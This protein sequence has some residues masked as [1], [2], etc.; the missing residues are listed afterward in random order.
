MNSKMDSSDSN[1]PGFPGPGTS[2]AT[3]SPPELNTAGTEL[4]LEAKS[5]KNAAQAMD[6]CRGLEANNKQRALRSADIQQLHD[7]KPPHGS[8][9]QLASAKSWQANASTL[10]LAGIVGRVSQRFVNA[11]ISQTYVTASAL[12]PIYKDWKTKSD[13]LRG[14]FTSLV[15]GW[16]GN[17]GLI[18]AI[19][20]E[21]VLQGYAY[22][23]FLDPKTWL[24]TFFKQE[25]CLVPEKSGQHARDLQ[26]FCARRDFRVDQF[27]ALFHDEGAA[28]T[29]G[30]NI[31]N[32]LEAAS[33]AVMQNPQDDAA[34]TIFRRFADMI[35]E[36]AIGLSVRGSGERV[37]QTW[38]LFNREY[39]G[40]VSFWL[41]ARDTGKLL[42]FSFKEFDRM[43]DVLTMFSFEAGN[44]CI[45]SS[46]GLGRKLAAL[47]VM[48]ELFRCGII[49]NARMGGMFVVPVDAAQKTKIAPAM[50]APFIFLDRTAVD[51]QNAFQ[52]EVSAEG[53]QTIDVLIDS[54]AEQAVGAYL[55]A[56]ITDKGRTERTATEATIDSRREN[57]AADIMIRRCLDQDA[58]LRQMQQLRAFSDDNLKEAR[59]IYD[60]T[61]EDPD[62]ELE[63]LLPKDLD[64]A[65]LMRALVE[66]IGEGYTDHEMQVWARSQA[67]AFAHVT[68]GAVQR[69]V[70]I[71]QQ[72][73][74][75]NPNIDQSALVYADL[76]GIVGPDMAKKLFIPKADETLA[77]EAARKQQI[78]TFTMAGSGQPI[79]VSL[80]DNHIIEGATV[81]EFLTTVAKLLSEPGTDERILKSAEL[82][83]NHLG[84][85]LA[86]AASLGQDKSEA[87]KEEEK[88]YEGFKKQLA[89]VVEIREQA[90]VAQQIATE[91]VRAESAGITQ[92]PAQAPNIPGDFEAPPPRENEPTLQVA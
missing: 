84:A 47:A 27:I 62:T 78:E 90:K 42:R 85:H 22:A 34:T 53:Y 55:A 38:M 13:K 75:G 2:E 65:N 4:K 17:T 86:A 1:I 24:P 76:E 77:V 92:M 3:I 70:T 54:W 64:D 6:I 82:N 35:D 23:V 30:Y 45:H 29:A 37:V 56:Q 66:C 59:R 41:L 52:L 58:T 71:A 16:D 49:D 18:N 74:T 20:V 26:F 36:G 31:K 19:A 63:D 33:K 91:A 79:D 50:Q 87:F 48:K 10:W 39:D 32:C 72:K 8:G 46:K 61:Q 51:L 25:E 60:K 43:Q 73:Y 9:E 67:S 81:V 68:E 69:G 11:I 57:E 89:Q 7:G 5:V 28:E 15:R 80:R 88:F 14:K 21:T 40:K 44:G 83:L 12:P